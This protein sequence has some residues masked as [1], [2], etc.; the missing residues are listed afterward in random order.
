[1]VAEFS[2]SKIESRCELHLPRVFGAG[3]DAEV[4]CAE[5]RAW[6]LKIR[7]IADIKSPGSNLRQIIA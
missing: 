5:R 7:A 4:S 1:L 6:H 3:D 2:N